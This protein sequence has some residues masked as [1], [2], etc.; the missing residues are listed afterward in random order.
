MKFIAH[1]GLTNGPDKQLE[2]R[3]EQIEKVLNQGIDCEVDVWLI[4]NKW[5]LGHDEPQYEIPM[6]FLGKQG[7]W[8]HCKNLDAL[9][10]FSDSPIH[11]EYFWHQNDDYTLTSGNLIWTYPGK[12]LTKNSI[13]VMPEINEDYWEYV[14]TLQIFGVCTDYVKKISNEISTMSVRAT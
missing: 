8:I 4:Y 1:R 7:L 9:Y 3:P 11:Y 10:S 5:F 12:Y 13:A 14:K 6:N 2:N